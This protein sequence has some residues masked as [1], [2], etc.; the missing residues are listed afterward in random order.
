MRGRPDT[1]AKPLPRV[2]MGTPRGTPSL[3]L[4]LLHP[5]LLALCCVGTLVCRAGS[6]PPM[7][8]LRPSPNAIANT[9]RLT[10]RDP[11]TSPHKPS[12]FRQPGSSHSHPSSRVGHTR[13]NRC[14][15]GPRTPVSHAR[16]QGEDATS[17]SYDRDLCDSWRRPRPCTW[18][19]RRPW[20]CIQL[21]CKRA[22]WLAE[23]TH[24]FVVRQV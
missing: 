23:V 8:Q 6:E 17:S 19:P 22:R 16:R 7:P 3:L 14:G 1:S 11:C 12:H 20:I 10:S 24:Q 13:P 2:H 4:R 9:R 5:I 18:S 21:I 15:A